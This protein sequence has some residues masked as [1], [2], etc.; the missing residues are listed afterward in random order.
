MEVFTLMWDVLK[1]FDAFK[2]NFQRSEGFCKDEEA[3]K[4]HLFLKTFSVKLRLFQQGLRGFLN[5]FF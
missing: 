2:M 1:D 3:F 4:R 5:N